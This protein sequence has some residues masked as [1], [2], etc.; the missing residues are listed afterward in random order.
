[1]IGKKE[2]RREN[3]FVVYA[4]KKKA[5]LS[6]PIGWVMR[7]SDEMGLL[8]LS[9][10]QIFYRSYVSFWKRFC[11][12]AGN[13]ISSWCSILIES[14]RNSY[15]ESKESLREGRCSWHS[16]NWQLCQ[17]NALGRVSL[18]PGIPG[19]C[20]RWLWNVTI[21]LKNEQCKTATEGWHS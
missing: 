6:F 12:W 16:F 8:S 14:T 10:E 4:K 13:R 9:T 3:V 19:D 5:W 1:M 11:Y 2:K 21:M 7:S 17:W 20:W 18:V 15:K